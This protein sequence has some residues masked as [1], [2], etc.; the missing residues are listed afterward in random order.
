MQKG[1]K[2]RLRPF[3]YLA[4]LKLLCILEQPPRFPSKG[5][6]APQA[7]VADTGTLHMAVSRAAPSFAPHPGANKKSRLLTQAALLIL[8]CDS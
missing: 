1:R 7:G 6:V 3:C 5:G 2:R 4:I 8:Y